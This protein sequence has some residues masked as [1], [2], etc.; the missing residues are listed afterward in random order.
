MELVWVRHTWD[1][2]N[3]RLPCVRPS[4]YDFRPA[5]AAE[6][7]F[8]LQVIL[9]AYASDPIWAPMM[10]GITRR[11]TE[12]VE[13]T[14]GRPDAAYMIAACSGIPIGLSGVATHHWTDQ[15]LLT[16]ICVVPEY[17]RRGVGR[18]L[19]AESLSW[20]RA[21]GLAQAQVYTVQG[22][23]ADQKV[24]RLFG[25]TRVV[26]V[27]YPGLRPRPSSEGGRG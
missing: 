2:T 25:S 27:D 1:L 12:R 3:L 18:H 16:G 5:T 21:Q 24:Y 11:M 26:G 7:P 8:A 14:F 13:E 20:L 6:R 10:E 19:L 22:S 15:H 23:L 17:R 9:D 4:G